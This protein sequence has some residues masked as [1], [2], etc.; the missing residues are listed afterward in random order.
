[1]AT[2]KPGKKKAVYDDPFRR[3][4]VRAFAELRKKDPEA[5]LSR[6]AHSRKLGPT[7]VFTWVQRY[8][9]EFGLSLP[10][11]QLDAQKR[12][13]V[14][15]VLLDGT[16]H[17]QIAE[18]EGLT[19]STVDGWVYR[20]GGQ[21]RAEMGLASAPE[22]SAP[23]GAAAQADPTMVVTGRPRLEPKQPAR[24]WRPPN[25]LRGPQPPP[26]P[27]PLARELWEE[28]SDPVL[29]DPAAAHA[30]VRRTLH[31]QRQGKLFETNGIT[32]EPPPGANSEFL[33]K[34]L[35]R[36]L[37]E[38]DAALLLLRMEMQSHNPEEE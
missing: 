24:R 13:V 2:K 35:K 31:E 32:R 7:V 22:P 10:A 3:E 25:S 6:F 30:L 5:G 12:R 29:D 1:L 26:Q 16:T 20:Y 14:G 33:Q 23:P 37:R 36:A 11:K 38:R 27:P 9:H 18:E 21:L 19:L 8:G 4:V 17:K 28:P 34:A 15:R